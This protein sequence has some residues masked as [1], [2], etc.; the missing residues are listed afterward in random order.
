MTLTH[1]API[2]FIALWA[3][4]SWL[5]ERSPWADQT[6]TSMMGKQR[7]LWV[8]TMAK[9]DLRMIDTSIIA[10]LQSGTAF[11]ASTSLLAIGGA[12]SLLNSADPILDLTGAI[13]YS[14]PMSS[15]L[16]EAKAVGLMG[17][18]AYAFLKFGWSYRLFNYTSILVGSVP[19]L[20]EEAPHEVFRAQVDRTA[21]MSIQA[22]KEFA[23]GQ[24]AFF[25]AIAY[26]GWFLSDIVFLISMVAMYGMLIFRQFF[27]PANAALALK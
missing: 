25:I 10:G 14:S 4:Q 15:Q 27:S 21:R 7:R 23:R 8:E 18:F 16:F 26:L 6:L 11:F 13:P 5:I 3:L 1:I 20:S 22:G 12:F 9:R 24:R 19:M 17:I 2:I